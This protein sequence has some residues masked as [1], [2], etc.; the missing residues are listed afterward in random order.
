MREATKPS[1]RKLATSSRWGMAGS[2]K[3][4]T[5]RSCGTPRRCSKSWPDAVHLLRGGI[6]ARRLHSKAL[7]TLVDDLIKCHLQLVAAGAQSVR[8][9]CDCHCMLRPMPSE[10]PHWGQ[11]E[12]HSAQ[13]VV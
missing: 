3:A 12:K 2:P 4:S 13:D 10:C 7:R 6:A 8:M 5:R 9:G 1:A 11:A